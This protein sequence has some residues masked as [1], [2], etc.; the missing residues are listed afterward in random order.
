MQQKERLEKQLD[1]IREIDTSFL[2]P[3][4]RKRWHSSRPR[5]RISRHFRLIWSQV[6]MIRSRTTFLLLQII[7]RRSVS[8]RSAMTVWSMRSL[9]TKDFWLCRKMSKSAMRSFFRRSRAFL[10]LSWAVYFSISWIMDLRAAV[11]ADF[12]ILLFPWPHACQL[13]FLPYICETAKTLHK[14]LT[15]KHPNPIS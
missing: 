10:L 15:T 1:F 7:S 4:V 5:S 3:D 11:H 9:R 8:T 2:F 6:N 12:R 13:V 14:L